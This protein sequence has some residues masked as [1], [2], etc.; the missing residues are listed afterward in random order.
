MGKVNRNHKDSLFRMIFGDDKE[1]ALALYNAINGT[2]YEDASLITITTLKDAL[3]I[4]IK[5]DIGFIIEDSLNLYEQQSTYN[6]NMPLRG[7]GY[8]DKMYNEYM[9]MQRVSTSEIYGSAL[10]KIPTPRYYVFYNGKQHQPEVRNLKLSDAYSGEGDVEVIAHMININKGNNQYL[11]DRCQPLADYA[12]VISRV[13]SNQ[14]KGMNLEN[15]I[16]GALNSCIKDGILEEILRKER[17]KV[18]RS[19]YEG[20][21]AEELEMLRQKEKKI[22]EAAAREEGC[23][24]ERNRLSKLYCAMKKDKRIDDYLKAVEDTSLLDSYLQEYGIH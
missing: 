3:Y 15:A 19:L 18:A 21:S 2:E 20:I 11:L 22:A 10:V 8:F 13:R 23:K 7:L 4:D 12:E 1:N 14:A 17:A 24:K 5:N 6:P 16:D 9:A